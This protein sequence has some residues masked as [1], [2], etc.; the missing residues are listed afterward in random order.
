[1]PAPQRRERG[2]SSEVESG[3]REKRVERQIFFSHPNQR[4]TAKAAF[5]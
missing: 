5:I 1:M 4:S 3:A 2:R